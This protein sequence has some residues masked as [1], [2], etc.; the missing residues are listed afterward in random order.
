MNSLRALAGQHWRHPLEETAVYIASRQEISSPG[1]DC[2]STLLLTQPPFTWILRAVPHREG[3]GAG[4]ISFFSFPEALREDMAQS[5][6]STLCQVV[7]RYER[8]ILQALTDRQMTMARCRASSLYV[9]L[10]LRK[11]SGGPPFLPKTTAAVCDNLLCRENWHQMPYAEFTF[12]LYLRTFFR[13]VNLGDYEVFESLNGRSLVPYQAVMKR[14]DWTQCKDDF[15][16]MFNVAGRVYR[17]A[18]RKDKPQIM[19][20]AQPREKYIDAQDPPYEPKRGKQPFR[21]TDADGGMYITHTRT[22]FIR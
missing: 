12:P 6:T 16:A 7:M 18:F 14:A 2:H 5:V 22:Q 15:L 19:E 13:M 1:R 9:V 17:Q 8:L 10:A 4:I 3:A 11:C 20:T 21:G